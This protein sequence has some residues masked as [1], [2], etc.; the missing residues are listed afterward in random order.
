MLKQYT[1]NSIVTFTQTLYVVA[2]DWDDAHDK[3]CDMVVEEHED[4]DIQDMSVD[5]IN[6]EEYVDD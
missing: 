5:L 1:I 3:A 4:L 2:K 6:E